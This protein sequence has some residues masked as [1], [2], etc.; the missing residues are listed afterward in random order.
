MLV[1][2]YV[3]L[4][5]LLGVGIA[6]YEVPKLVRQ[7]MWRELVAFSGFLLAG[8]ALTIAQT[9]GL[10]VPNPTRAIEFIFSP[11]SKLIH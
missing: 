8:L 7:K 9:L 2:W 4:I 10:P 3:L 6:F 5:L 11:L 1:F